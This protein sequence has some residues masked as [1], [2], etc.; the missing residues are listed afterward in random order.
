[1]EWLTAQR[2]GREC[3]KDRAWCPE[4]Q[5]IEA[6]AQP[7]GRRGT[8]KSELEAGPVKGHG[9]ASGKYSCLRPDSADNE[10]QGPNPVRA[11][12]G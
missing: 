10:W 6:W 1:M 7:R 9:V 12:S 5:P 2:R 3:N 11:P 8:Q 4:L